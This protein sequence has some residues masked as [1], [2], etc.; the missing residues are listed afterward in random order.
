[1]GIKKTLENIV[2]VLAK[3]PLKAAL[4]GVA[5]VG[6]LQMMADKAMASGSIE[7]IG[8]IHTEFHLN[9]AGYDTGAG[10]DP[11][12]NFFHTFDGIEHR[13]GRSSSVSL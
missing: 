1:M 3:A 2:N 8:Y 7:D 13:D 10:D 11:D 6:T 12:E 9:D 4:T 5:A